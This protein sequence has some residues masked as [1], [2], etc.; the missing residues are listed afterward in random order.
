MNAWSRYHPLFAP[1]RPRPPRRRFAYSGG[2]TGVVALAAPDALGAPGALGA[3]PSLAARGPRGAQSRRPSSASD[4]G[5]THI[6]C[7]TVTPLA[8]GELESALATL[9][10]L[11]L[12]EAEGAAFTVTPFTTGAQLREAA[13]VLPLRCVPLS[14]YCACSAAKSGTHARTHTH[15]NACVHPRVPRAPTTR[16]C[17]SRCAGTLNV[18]VCVRAC[19]RACVRTRRTVWTRDTLRTTSTC[20]R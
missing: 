17:K 3:Q 18:G 2:T 8:A 9:P 4:T 16:V 20:Q 6:P 10:P 13:I 19:V 15:T 12:G 14:A 11:P 1:L 7:T 5:S